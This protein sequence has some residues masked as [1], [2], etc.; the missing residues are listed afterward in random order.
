MWG[1]RSEEFRGNEGQLRQV[2][3][4]RVSGHETELNQQQI[5]PADMVILALG[6]TGVDQQALTS[7]PQLQWTKSGT[8]AAQNYAT[9]VAG[10]FAA[11]DACRGAS[12][13]VWAIEEGRRMAQAIHESLIKL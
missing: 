10:V 13:I 6:F 8:L 11:G 1:W 2:L 3:L 12:L 9:S 5:L 4:R 7:I